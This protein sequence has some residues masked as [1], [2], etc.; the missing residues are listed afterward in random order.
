VF[1]QTN[2]FG[3]LRARDERPSCRRTAEQRDE[4]IA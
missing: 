1:E 2:A 3:L 4:V